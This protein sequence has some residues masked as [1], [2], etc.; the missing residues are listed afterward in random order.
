MTQRATGQIFLQTPLGLN[1]FSAAMIGSGCPTLHNLSNWLGSTASTPHRAF[2]SFQSTG[3]C[4]TEWPVRR[5][6]CLESWSWECVPKASL[7]MKLLITPAPQALDS[8]GER[9]AVS[10][11][12]WVYTNAQHYHLYSFFVFWFK[13]K[14]NIKKLKNVLLSIDCAHSYNAIHTM[15]FPWIYIVIFIYIY[16]YFYF[17]SRYALSLKCK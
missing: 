7:C 14:T 1:S 9:P 8:S 16:F 2:S 11:Q 17:L 3:S 12:P 5:S 10:P 13:C 6:L 4:F 15:I